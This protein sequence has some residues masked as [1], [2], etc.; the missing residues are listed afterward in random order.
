MIKNNIKIIVGLCAGM[1]LIVGASLVSAAVSYNG[2]TFDSTVT[3]T[4]GTEYGVDIISGTSIPTTNGKYTLVSQLAFYG[5]DPANDAAFSNEIDE[6]TYTK[7]KKKGTTTYLGQSGVHS[8]NGSNVPGNPGQILWYIMH[9]STNGL[10]VE[11]GEY[12]VDAVL[13]GQVVSTYDVCLPTFTGANG[14]SIGNVTCSGQPALPPSGGGSGL[15]SASTSSATGTVST[16]NLTG[17]FSFPGPGIVPNP[18]CNST[19][20]TC[21]LTTNIKGLNAGPVAVK[22]KFYPSSDRD[23]GGTKSFTVDAHLFGVTVQHNQNYTATITVPFNE[24]MTLMD[25]MQ[26]LDRRYYISFVD[27][28]NGAHESNKTNFNFGTVLP[29]PPAPTVPMLDFEVESLNAP[30]TTATIDGTLFSSSTLGAVMVD[31]YLAPVGTEP[32]KI[33][34][35]YQGDLDSAGAP[36]TIEL[37]NLLP[38]TSYNYRLQEFTTDIVIYNGTFATNI[39]SDQAGGLN[40]IIGVCG[41]D[42]ISQPQASEPAY[43]ALCDSGNPTEV[44]GTGPWNWICEGIDGGESESCT[45]SALG[46]NQNL[47]LPPAGTTTTASGAEVEV[48]DGL[49]WNF[50]KNPFKTLD[51]F[52]KIIKA[53]V[54]NIVLPIMI[55]FIA[56]MLIY[57]GYLFVRAREGG[58][59]DGLK[60]A[61]QT[62]LYTLIGATLV[63]GAFVIANALQGTL[64]SLV[65]ARYQPTVHQTRV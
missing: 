14:T 15:G 22:L 20:Q 29:P 62:L 11:P 52:P 9:S 4:Q 16:S 48:N 1:I 46:G 5:L 34:S 23:M 57:S 47:E 28:A 2:F 18:T 55:P 49:G 13:N 40:A 21:T 42:A 38:N 27:V 43:S 53:V 24:L 8:S 60:K 36:I 12:T 58:E 6:K 32:V 17:T 51:S 63:L 35:V 41:S 33:H 56:L 26:V 65:G 37:P 3:T 45:A 7:I 25:S 10:F 59:V 30:A 61:K 50:L 19:A 44:T 64:N 39:S 54:N 31:I